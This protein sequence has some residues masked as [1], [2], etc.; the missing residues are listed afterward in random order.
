M[1]AVMRNCRDHNQDDQE[2]AVVQQLAP[3]ADLTFV[4]E[5]SQSQIEAAATAGTGHPLC[6]KAVECDPQE[7]SMLQEA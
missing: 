4:V 5:R 3:S 6:R 1:G 7:R 2:Y